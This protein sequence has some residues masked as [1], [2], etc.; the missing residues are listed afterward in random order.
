MAEGFKF[1]HMS[2]C[3][4]G[5][6]REGLLRDI[7]TESFK[8]AID[9]C[10]E[11][12]VDF[13][14][15]S[16]DLFH[17]HIP[18]MS[19]AEEAARSMKKA[20][21][22]GIEIYLVYGSH[23]YSSTEKS[24]IDVLNSTGLIKKVYSP[25][26][27]E[28]DKIKLDFTVDNKTGAKIVG[29]SGRKTGLESEYFK[30][31]N[32]DHLE[33][34][35]GFKIFVFHSAITEY[36]PDFVTDIGVPL[37]YFP[38]G[39]NYYAAGHVHSTFEK[40]EKG[41]GHIVYPGPIFAATLR[42]LEELENK[43]SG[44]F[45]VE[46][47]GKSVTKCKFVPINTVDVDVIRYDASNRTSSKAE[48]EMIKIAESSKVKDKVVLLKIKGELSGGKPSDINF[49]IIK[50]ALL[51]NDALLVE[52]SKASLTTK[53]KPKI[54]VQGDTKEEI[55]RKLFKEC[56]SKLDI[57]EKKLLEESGVNISCELLNLLKKEKGPEN[58]KEHEERVLKSVLEML[59]I[60]A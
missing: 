4:L 1:A 51:N 6:F 12:D 19:V 42:D 18:D 22:R 30:N 43:K 11:N 50:E 47:D 60:G 39:F 14:I 59:K 20:K 26:Y 49:Q 17:I 58:V 56:I 33:K 44:F 48:E 34:E 54:Y 46:S 10:I 52:V 55:E 53:E 7:N 57:K 5:A 15:I 13:I 3:H 36:K 40:E 32:L 29:I 37:S 9:M 2:D 28:K 27:D 23:D 45:I 35:D 41:Y 38:K 31:L 25:D 8:K 21:D 24:I 16:G